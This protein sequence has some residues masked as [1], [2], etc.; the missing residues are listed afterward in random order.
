[1]LVHH[2]VKAFISPPR[3]SIS[4]AMS[5]ALRRSVPLKNICSI[6]CET[7]PSSGGSW[8]EPTFTHTPM[9]TERDLGSVSDTTRIPF[10][11]VS[12][13]YIYFSF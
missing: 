3:E 11:S 7:P 6:K 13:L 8:R 1:M 4:M 2:L 9:E 12:F 10:A 5:F